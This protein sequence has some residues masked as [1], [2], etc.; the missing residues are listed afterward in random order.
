MPHIHETESVMIHGQLANIDREIVGLIQ[1]VN[2]IPGVRTTACCQGSNERKNPNGNYSNCYFMFEG[3][4]WRE[5]GEILFERMMPLLKPI[6]LNGN[7][8]VSG[9]MS[10]TSKHGGVRGTVCWAYDVT[11]QIYDALMLLA[12]KAS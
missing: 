7:S 5:I 12:V 9:D 8:A 10:E 4:S 1:M 11:S 2:T 3:S 6:T